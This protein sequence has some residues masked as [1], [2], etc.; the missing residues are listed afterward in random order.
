M[1]NMQYSTAENTLHE[2]YYMFKKIVVDPQKL[3]ILVIDDSKKDL[4][5]L[6]ELLAHESGLKP[7][8][9]AYNNSHE[10]LTD[11][12]AGM[13]KPNIIITDLIMPGINGKIVLNRLKNLV[14]TKS[15]P[16]IVHSSMNTYE[17]VSRVNELDAHAFFAK[18]MDIGAFVNYVYGKE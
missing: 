15:I 5:L 9:H 10:A 6:Y 4:N 7:T 17:Y 16:V 1:L 12:E 14:K 2:T 13:V 3:E 18:P 11:L 8:V